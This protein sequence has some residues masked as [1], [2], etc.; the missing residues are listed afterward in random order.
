MGYKYIEYG[1][2]VLCLWIL[3]RL[4]LPFEQKY[5]HE[6]K[7][8]AK[9]PFFRTLLGVL[10]I[11]ASLYSIPVASLL[12]LITFFLIADVHLISTTKI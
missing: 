4:T 12:F 10:I 1:F 2:I 7:E 5:Q 11:Y 6:I 9:E 8:M 3:V